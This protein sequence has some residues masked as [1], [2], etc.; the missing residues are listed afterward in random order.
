[1]E[2]I[3]RQA[4]VITGQRLNQRVPEPPTRDEI[5]RLARTLNDMLARLEASAKRQERFV[6]DAAHELRTPLASLRTR[7]ETAL[8]RGDDEAGP[9]LLQGLWSETVRL[10]SLVDH[11]LLLAR[12]DAGTLRA[13]ARPVDL[14]DVVGEV[15][16]STQ[17]GDVVLRA[18]SVEPVQVTGDAALLEQVLR[19]LV[20]NAVR[21]AVRAVDVSLSSEGSHAVLTVDDDGPGIPE[22]E[23]AEVFQRFVRLDDSRDRKRGGVGLGLAIVAEIVRVHSGRVDVS[24]SPSGGARLT[25]RLPMASE[26]SEVPADLRLLGT[27]GRASH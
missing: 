12:S 22:S 7:L 24:D 2:A 26:Q 20:E 18:R 8:L 15:L 4:E 10:G 25:V 27:A 1:V 16:S 5:Y 14:D 21:H 3:R 13:R 17:A 23:R 19:N 9:E 11:L 6:A